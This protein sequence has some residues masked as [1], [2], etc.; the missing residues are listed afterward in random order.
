MDKG[1]E[2]A[3]RFID[4]EI[5]ADPGAD[6]ARLIELACQKFDLTPL[7]GEFLTNKLLLEK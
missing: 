5:K 6:K 3:F 1:L 2:D 4:A 7:Q